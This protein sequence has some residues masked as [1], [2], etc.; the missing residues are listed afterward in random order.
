MSDLKTRFEQAAQEAQQLPK[1][2]GNDVLLQLYAL[3][4]QGN[5]GDTTGARPGILDMQ[6]RMKYDAWAKLKGT[7]SEQA[8]HDYIALVEKLKI[9][10]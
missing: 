2:P 6:G 3:Y 1:R 4:K 9:G 10:G 5:V 7:T 8:M